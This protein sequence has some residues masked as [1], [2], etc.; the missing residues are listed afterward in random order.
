[1]KG[2]KNI[3]HLKRRKTE[4][5]GLVGMGTLCYNKHWNENRLTIQTLP[6]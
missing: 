3:A 1:M 4:N 6:S 5:K 2:N